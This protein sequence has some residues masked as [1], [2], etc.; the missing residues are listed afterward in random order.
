[1]RAEQQSCSPSWSCFLSSSEEDLT[2]HLVSQ[3]PL[4]SPGCCFAQHGVGAGPQMRQPASRTWLGFCRV[5]SAEVSS[6]LPGVRQGH[7]GKVCTGFCYRS[8]LCSVGTQGQSINKLKKG[9]KD[10]KAKGCGGRKEKK[11][12]IFWIRKHQPQALRI[13]RAERAKGLTLVTQRKNNE[14]YLPKQGNK[15]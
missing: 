8:L 4:A 6:V 5:F 10:K 13:F 1:M 7:R 9:K 15:L 2:I 3:R 14:R 12:N 11:C